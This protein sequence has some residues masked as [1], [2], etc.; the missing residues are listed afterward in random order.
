MLIVGLPFTE[1]ALGDTAGGGTPYGA[2][3]IVPE[4]GKRT[5]AEGERALA[6]ALGARV[7]GVALRLGAGG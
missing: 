5:L 1:T 2:S 6:Q 3:R 7:A 4:G